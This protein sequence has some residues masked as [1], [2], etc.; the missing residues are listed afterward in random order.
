MSRKFSSEEVYASIGGAATYDLVK[1]MLLDLVE[2]QIRDHAME[3]CISIESVDSQMLMDFT[4]ISIKG[5]MY[6]LSRDR[7]R[8]EASSISYIYK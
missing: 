1:S 5:V 4:A 2:I 7:K 6:Y 8:V 3:N